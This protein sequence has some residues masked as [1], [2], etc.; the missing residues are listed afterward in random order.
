ME[1]PA[2]EFLGPAPEA[3][4]SSMAFAVMSARTLIFTAAANLMSSADFG[5]ALA[6]NMVV[7]G[8][9]G[10]GEAADHAQNRSR[11]GAGVESPGDVERQ[12]ARARRRRRCNDQINARAHARGLRVW[13]VDNPSTSG[14]SKSAV[15]AAVHQSAFLRKDLSLRIHFKQVI[16][17]QIVLVDRVDRLNRRDFTLR[18]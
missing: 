7:E 8:R 14:G 13:H 12:R 18:F 9:E 10:G 1:T 4:T 2:L 3:L 16:T 5:L 17:Y 6:L 11:W 15:R